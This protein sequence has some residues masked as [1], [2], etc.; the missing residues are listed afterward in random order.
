MGG[1]NSNTKIFRSHRAK[2]RHR[3]QTLNVVGTWE[4]VAV[5]VAVA[6][7]ALFSRGKENP[8][9]HK[10]KYFSKRVGQ[11]KKNHHAES[12]WRNLLN[13]SAQE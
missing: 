5:A 2:Q 10:L 8:G 7:A 9:S 13:D 11:K 6:V 4:R 3:R 12:G 1:R